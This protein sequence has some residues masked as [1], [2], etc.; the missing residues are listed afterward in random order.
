ME[1]YQCSKMQKPPMDVKGSLEFPSI[2]D[3][4]H[5]ITLDV[6][7]QTRPCF[8]IG[9]RGGVDP[10]VRSVVLG[11]LSRRSLGRDVAPSHTTVDDK[12]RA[13]DKAA[14]I[15]SEEENTLSLL[16]SLAESASR[17]VNLATGALGLVI[18]KPVL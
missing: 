8:R 16:D 4:A 2:P 6:K 15:A 11:R 5:I 3:K 12:V 1:F 7:S 13:I 18:A 14:L 17:E 9:S 10:L